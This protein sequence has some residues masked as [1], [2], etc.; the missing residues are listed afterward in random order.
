MSDRKVTPT[1]IL[2]AASDLPEQEWLQLRRSGLG[3]SDIA[4]LV[5]LSKYTSPYELYLD[6][7]GELPEIPRSDFLERAAYWGHKH[8]PLLAERFTELT[9]LSVRRVGMIRHQD[10]PWRLVNLDRQVLGCPDG[11]CAQEIKNRSAYKASEWG[12]SGDPDGVPDTEAIQTHWEMSVTGYRHIHVSVLINGND[13]RHY[14]VDY[15]PQIEQDVLAMAGSF[16]QRVQDGN[17]PPVDGS[18]AV[19]ELLATLWTGREGTE[20]LIPAADVEPLKA[21]LQ[22]L[23]AAEKDTARQIAEIKNQ[24]A[25]MLG[26]AEEAV[27]DG[28]ILFSRRQNGAFNA[29]RFTEAYPDLAGKYTHLKPAIDT[30]ALAADH[31]DIY[32]A[33]RAR[34]LRIPGGKK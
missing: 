7:R 19:T 28:E 32:R 33:H 1:G 30:K 29:K 20:K 8:E 17:P 22:R 27:W 11:P 5:G 31:P 26:D 10:V 12:E 18:E 4:A 6:K 23:Q 9:G 13:D 34:V 15:D 16:W 2:V 21:E 14:R 3:G 25:V 24:M